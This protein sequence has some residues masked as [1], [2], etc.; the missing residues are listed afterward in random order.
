MLAIGCANG[1]RPRASFLPLTRKRS[2]RSPSTSTIS[3]ARRSRQGKSVAQAD[4]VVEA[5]LARMGPLA[6]AVVE[7]AKRQRRIV[8]DGRSSMSGLGA[9]LTHALRAVHLNRS[10]AAV[11]VLTLA[12]GIGACAAVFSIINAL[13]WGSLPYPNP[14]QLMIVMGTDRNNRAESYIVVVSEL[15]R[16]EARSDERV[17]GPLGVPDHQRGVGR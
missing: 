16:L 1:W 4:A 10:F 6:I 12:I 17:D 15:R 8:P 11:V 5:E 7:R 3:I 14:E 2:T 9:D 13:L